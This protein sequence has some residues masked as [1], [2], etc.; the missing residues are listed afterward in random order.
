MKDD[1]PPHDVS[2]DRRLDQQLLVCHCRAGVATTR[3]AGISFSA[4]ASGASACVII[5]AVMAKYADAA[6]RS[7]YYSPKSRPS[8]ARVMGSVTTDCCSDWMKS[9]STTPCSQR[10]RESSPLS[11]QTSPP[12]HA[13]SVIESGDRS[14]MGQLCERSCR[15]E[16]R[17]WKPDLPR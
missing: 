9:D 6:L 11:Y 13:H 2:G 3:P 1:A 15:C 4:R 17:W 5:L 8:I 12:R 10:H 7:L 14:A 16:L